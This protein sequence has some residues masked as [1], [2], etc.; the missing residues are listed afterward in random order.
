MLGLG[1]A[2]LGAQQ[3]LVQRDPYDFYSTAVPHLITHRSLEHGVSFNRGL[4]PDSQTSPSPRPAP[5]GPVR[6]EAPRNSVL[7]CEFAAPVARLACARA[8]L[9][10]RSFPG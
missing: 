8:P 3:L 5:C 2:I 7:G 9:R 6:V 1:F 4:S 10:S